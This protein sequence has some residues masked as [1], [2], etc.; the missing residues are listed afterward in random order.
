M[1]IDFDTDEVIVAVV[2]SGIEEEHSLLKDKVVP[3]VDMLEMDLKPN[4][5]NG[6]GTHVS[7]IIVQKAPDVKI[8][9]VKILDN[10][11]KGKGFSPFGIFY[12]ILRGADIINLSYVEEE[13][14]LTKWIIKYGAYK[15]VVFIA[16]AGN[17]GK[18]KVDF[19]ANL[20]EVISVGT[21]NPETEN[22]DWF[23]NFGEKIDYVAPGSDILSADL[24][25]RLSHKSG[26]SMSAAYVTGVVAYLKSEY[27]DKTRGELLTQLEL[28]S[29]KLDS[30]IKRIEFGR[31]VVTTQK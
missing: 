6:H 8:L 29:N 24:N 22:L 23:S 4:D 18:N 17:E 20:P 3:G 13:N 2:D 11:G 16:S 21:F 10:E 12:A 14:F 1:F 26:T 9:P 7:G 27:P 5:N 31:V 30:K 15:D 28:A 25:N 19:P